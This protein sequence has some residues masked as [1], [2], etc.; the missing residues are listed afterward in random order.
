LA[1][2]GSCITTILI[3]LFAFAYIYVQE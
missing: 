3:L 2:F 1:K